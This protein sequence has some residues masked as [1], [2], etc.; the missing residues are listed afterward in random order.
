MIN[1]KKWWTSGAM[2]PRCKILI[3]MVS[4]TNISQ[5]SAEST[6]AIILFLVINRNLNLM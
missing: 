6:E 2:D 3:L 5:F 1:G 4:L